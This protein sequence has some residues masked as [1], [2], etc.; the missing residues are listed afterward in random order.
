MSD[1]SAFP[2][3]TADKV[4][5]RMP[6]GMRDQLKDAAKTNNRTMNAEIVARLQESFAHP[7]DRIPGSPEEIKA[8]AEGVAQA[9]IEGGW[10]PNLSAAPNRPSGKK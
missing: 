9:L 3:D 7:K 10:S 2:S 1:K 8:F 6:E 5:V 4:L